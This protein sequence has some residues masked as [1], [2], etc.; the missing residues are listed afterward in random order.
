MNHA[1]QKSH[2][3]F[4]FLFFITLALII[5][6][7]DKDKLPPG[8]TGNPGSMASL[9][10]PTPMV[11][12]VTA[13]TQ[14]GDSGLPQRP[15]MF[16]NTG[17]LAYTVRPRSYIKPDGISGAPVNA[18]TAVFPGGSSGS[19]TLP[20]GTYT[21]CYDWDMGDI[22]GDGRVD[23][24]HTLDNRAVTLTAASSDSLDAAVI[25]DLAAPATGGAY[26]G[27]CAPVEQLETATPAPVIEEPVIKKYYPE[28]PVT[29]TGDIEAVAMSVTIDFKSSGVTGALSM[30]GDDYANAEIS[31]TIDLE[32][33]F[34]TATF[35]GAVGSMVYGI[36]VPW[37]GTIEGTVSDDFSSFAGMLVDDE[38]V[39][40]NFTV[41]R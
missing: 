13:T 22:D 15:V 32:F 27:K 36:E 17:T 19:L 11:I 18:S 35:S 41:T 28:A 14:N 9:D 7:C 3:V 4:S 20:L 1:F 12:I 39:S 26:M 30:G 29:Y 5:A 2:R 40:V 23:Y 31:G 37:W 21:W 34:V 38:G 10:D 25:V 8:D 16:H 6:A 24:L 33:L